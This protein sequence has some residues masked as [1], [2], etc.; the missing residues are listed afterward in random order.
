[1]ASNLYEG[2]SDCYVVR[3]DGEI[4]LSLTSKTEIPQDVNNLISFYTDADIVWKDRNPVYV[5]ECIEQQR[6]G[7]T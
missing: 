2:Q 3:S 4:L 1:M 7:N 5:Q 6:E